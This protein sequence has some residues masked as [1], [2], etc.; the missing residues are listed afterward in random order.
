[1]A[2]IG[3]CD[4]S[5]NDSRSASRSISGVMRHFVDADSRCNCLRMGV[6]EV[7]HE[8]IEFASLPGGFQACDPH[9]TTR[10]VTEF[11]VTS[12]PICADRLQQISARQTHGPV[13]RFVKALEPRRLRR[14]GRPFSET[15]IGLFSRRFSRFPIPPTP[16][17]RLFEGL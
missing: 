10:H 15:D 16:D 4:P 3:W 12:N 11:A 17:I 13:I 1:M 5:Q 7:P 14:R 8:L 2:S 9:Q 6:N